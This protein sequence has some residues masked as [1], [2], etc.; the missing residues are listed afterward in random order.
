MSAPDCGP[1]YRGQATAR[2]GPWPFRF[3]L[4]MPA[5]PRGRHR[6]FHTRPAV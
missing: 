2:R 5:A 4:P 6:H 1:A 3:P